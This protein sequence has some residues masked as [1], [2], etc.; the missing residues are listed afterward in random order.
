[1]QNKTT[2]CFEVQLHSEPPLSGIILSMNSVMLQHRDTQTSYLAQYFSSW[3]AIEGL[4]FAIAVLFHPRQ[5]RYNPDNPKA[6]FKRPLGNNRKYP[7]RLI[8]GS[9]S[10]AP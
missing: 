1:M 2:L 4:R 9:K 10:I 5:Y 8:L 7:T 3:Q 6:S